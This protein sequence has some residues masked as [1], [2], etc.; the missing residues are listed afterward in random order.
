MTGALIPLWIIGGPLI[1][2][3]VLAFS[4]KGPSSMPGGP[5]TRSDDIDPIPR[6]T[7]I[8]Y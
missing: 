6:K 8:P 7:A 1:G 5:G 4:F 3:L 2:M